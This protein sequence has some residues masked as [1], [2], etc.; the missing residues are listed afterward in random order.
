[1]SGGAERVLLAGRCKRKRHLMF[2]VLATSTG[3]VLEAPLYCAGRERETWTPLRREV[4]NAGGLR[5]CCPCRRTALIDD[6]AIRD[7]IARGK[8]RWL[9][10]AYNISSR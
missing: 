3:L 1:M 4:G 8:T 2:T 6:G 9:V 5:Y 10:D 7:R